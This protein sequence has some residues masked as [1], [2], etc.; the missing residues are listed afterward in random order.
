MKRALQIVLAL[1]IFL[2]IL[3]P[4]H[5][6][7][8]ETNEWVS[9]ADLPAARTGAATAVV[10]GKIY[11][12]GGA[13]SNDQASTG[14]KMNTSFVYDPG[15]NKWAQKANMPTSRAAVSAVAYEKKI[16]VIGGYYDSNNATYR[17]NKVEVYDTLT[18]SWETVSGL[19]IARSWSGVAILDGMIYVIG[20]ADNSKIL[21]TVERYDIKNDKWTTLK[22]FPLALNAMSATTVN[23][24]I[25]AYDGATG[26]TNGMSSAIYEYSPASDNW[27]QKNNFKIA[28]NASATTEYNGEIYLLGGRQNATTLSRVEVYNPVTNEVRSFTDLTSVRNQST[29]VS[30]NGEIFIIGGNNGSTI[31]NTVEKLSLKSEDSVEPEQPSGNRAILLVTMTSGLEK[32][33]DLSMQEVNSFIDWYETKQA[34][35]GKASYAID[36]HDNNKGPFKSRKDYILFDRVLTFEVSEY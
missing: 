9:V 27:I 17:T 28:A 16:Y 26:I 14:V 4:G 18:D 8:A 24:K 20:G 6:K 32:E 23:G 33:F 25:Y 3:F 5:A 30:V 13:A 29:A 11:V 36:K 19:T 22:N 2:I 7:A 12:F 31:L 21:S 10:D 35:S 15:T 1:S 34:G